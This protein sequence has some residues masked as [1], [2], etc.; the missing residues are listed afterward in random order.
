MRASDIMT[1]SVIAVDESLSVGEVVKIMAENNVGA[2]VIQTPRP[3]FGIFTQG[4]LVNRVIAQ[5]RN[6]EKTKIA[7]VM[8]ES[9]KCAQ[10]DDDLN[11]I[12]SIMYDE[13]VKY[14]PVMRGRELV[15]II[16]H[17]DLF[18]A[19]FRSAEGYKEEVI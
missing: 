18:K 8:T 2:L 10:A 5:N 19:L 14:L 1:R 4:D 17:A 11:E 13:N 16:S 7:D 9:T 6:L 12:T 15:G 3:T